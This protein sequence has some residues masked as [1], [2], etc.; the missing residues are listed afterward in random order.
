MHHLI[1]DTDMGNDCDDALA[2]AVA[3]ALVSRGICQLDAV[4]LSRAGHDAAAFCAAINTF[5]GRGDIPV[6]V[7]RE[8]RASAENRFLHLA[9]HW[10]HRYDADRAPEALELLRQRLRAL[11]DQSVTI[12]QIGFATNTAALLVDPADVALVRRKVR[13]LSVMAGA[14]VPIA[15]D[16]AFKEFNVICD[17]PAMQQV[18]A[19][20]PTPIVWN[21][22]EVGIALRFPVQSIDHDFAWVA[23]HPVVEAYRA[24]CAVGENRPSWD[25]VSVLVAAEPEAGHAALSENGRVVVAADGATQFIADPAGT[26]RILRLQPDQQIRVGETLRLLASQPR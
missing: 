7:M 4:I 17:I 26:H 12:V 3:H 23:R 22:F 13:Q 9:G 24:Y 11:P 16:A 15:G 18:A 19:H 25:L 1:I 5:Y 10:P 8:G 14:F 6:G 2:L 21:G 20:W